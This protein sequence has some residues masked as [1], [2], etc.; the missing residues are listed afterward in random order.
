MRRVARLS[1]HVHP[2]LAEGSFAS[3]GRTL[4]AQIVAGTASK[5]RK[6]GL[7]G[8]RQALKQHRYAAVDGETIKEWLDADMLPRGTSVEE[9]WSTFKNLWNE[10]PSQ[11]SE[12]CETI[13]EHKKVFHSSYEFPPGLSDEGQRLMRQ[14]DGIVTDEDGTRRQ[15]Y[16]A[17]ETTST[18]GEATSHY[19]RYYPALPDKWDNDPM[20][21]AMHRLFAEIYAEPYQRWMGI[22]PP[23]GSDMF[24]FC[25]R[26]V[27][28]VDNE[29][30][31]GDPGP[32]GVH[33]DGGTAAMI[34]VVRRDN[35]KPETGGTRIWSPEQATGKPT[36][37]DLKSSKL[38]HTWKPTQQFDALFFLDESVTHEAL[39]GE[40]IDHHSGALRDML[41]LDVRR[42]DR[43]WHG[44]LPIQTQE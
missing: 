12:D 9:S 30:L 15:R 32:E 25:Y 41:I 17:H 3:K 4:T 2:A 28:S 13:Y 19:A 10:C 40:L 20:M 38:L 1:A 21:K 43:S 7:D 23:V 5:S 34:L 11:R 16:F 37:A 31:K 36:T 18:Q 35:I 6:Q 22:Q 39:R 27:M 24:Q 33:V 8:L 26:T 44:I 14:R 42:Q 29:I